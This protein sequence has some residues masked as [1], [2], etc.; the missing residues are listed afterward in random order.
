MLFEGNNIGNRKHG[1][2]NESQPLFQSIVRQTLSGFSDIVC[3]S[4][5]SITRSVDIKQLFLT[6]GGSRLLFGKI[7]WGSKCIASEIQKWSRTR[8]QQL[9]HDFGTIIRELLGVYSNS[10]SS[11]ASDGVVTYSGADAEA[12]LT[13]VEG[14]R[15]K[16]LLP[17]ATFGKLWRCHIAESSILSLQCPDELEFLAI[18]PGTIRVAM[19]EIDWWQINNH[20]EE[21]PDIV[22]NVTVFD[23]SAKYSPAI[24]CILSACLHSQ[25]NSLKLVDILNSYH[26]FQDDDLWMEKAQE[27][28]KEMN[29]Y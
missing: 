7:A 23:K 29:S 9:M 20:E 16:L 27:E 13:V 15:F 24:R 26:I 25:V 5:F 8:E 10:A 18:G 11:I 21:N 14:T 17:T 1:I 19:Q 28:F 22:F 12:G 4:T 6:E 3:Q 2:F